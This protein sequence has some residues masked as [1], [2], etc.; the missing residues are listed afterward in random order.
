MDNWLLGYIGR[1]TL[2]TI[3]GAI[4]AVAAAK[5]SER[6]GWRSLV[7][8]Y[9][10]RMGAMA[11]LMLLCGQ[12]PPDVSGWYMHGQWMVN[13]GMFPGVDFLTP[14]YLG[15]NGLIALAVWIYDSPFSIVC[16]FSVVEFLGVLVFYRC[17]QRMMDDR[18]SKQAMILYCTSPIVMYNSWLGAQDEPI[19]MLALG[20]L[21][22]GLV[23][24]RTTLH[25]L[26]SVF[27]G[28][29]F[30]KVI[31]LFF[32]QGLLLAK[33]YKTCFLGI[34]SLVGYVTVSK[35]LGADPFNMV[36][37]R[38]PGLEGAGDQIRQIVT[39]GNIW[40]LVPA[41]PT[42][43]QDLV[44]LAALSICTGPI[45][46][47]IFFGKRSSEFYL[48]TTVILSVSWLFVFDIFYR[49]TFATYS[50]A[51]LPLVMAV[52]LKTP[53]K[54]HELLC[55]AVW[56]LLFGVKDSLWYGQGR[57]GC[58]ARYIVMSYNVLLCMMTMLML[59]FS[60]VRLR[61]TCNDECRGKFI[62]KR[63]LKDEES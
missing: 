42:I 10:L 2:V 5:F 60:L 7:A 17:F 19:I 23:L 18:R 36:F 16:L 11:V 14:Y 26:A 4:G 44:L 35:L 56:S 49:M 1:V 6:I 59:V 29:F 22:Y 45:A 39:I 25:S 46:I 34:V 12:M 62:K 53:A 30:S 55:L 43:I 38:E 15:M 58:Y 51:L 28:L 50:V 41:V 21:L 27:C 3:I 63:E 13:K 47:K 24:N 57:I 31:A 32:M 40:S 33:R 8:Y 48:W 20:C 61:L 52:A 54:V 9:A 37:G